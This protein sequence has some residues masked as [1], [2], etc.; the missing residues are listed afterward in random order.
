MR[1]SSLPRVAGLLAA[2]V[3]VGVATVGWLTVEVTAG[4]VPG[5]DVRVHTWV[6][7]HRVTW[8]DKAMEAATWLG[9]NVTL[10]P[11]LL[12]A[13]LLF[14]RARRSWRPVVDIAVVYGA[15]VGVYTLMK[16][17]VDRPRPP[18]TDWLTHA[19]GA[20]FPSGHA[21]QATA[22]WGVLCVL[23][24]AGRSPRARALLAAAASAIVLVVAAS[25][26]YLGVHWLTDV[27]AGVAIGVTILA[28]RE[29]AR[30]L[31]ATFTRRLVS[32]T[33]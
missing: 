25:R 4:G 2:V 16:H 21:T 26:V 20:A 32:S 5:A 14:A 13:A 12:L 22:A 31:H 1:S 10:V 28:A 27:L 7:Q 6:V 8:L 29:L 3:L 15:A 11:V 17:L 18:A 23:L 30:A 19:S 9:S 33:T 24:C